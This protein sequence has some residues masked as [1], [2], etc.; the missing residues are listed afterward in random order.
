MLIISQIVNEIFA[1]I[2]HLTQR[3]RQHT[4][5]TNSVITAYHQ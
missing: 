2:S 1:D 5:S 4:I 3:W